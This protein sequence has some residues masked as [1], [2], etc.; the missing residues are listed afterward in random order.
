[1]F[2][3]I[4][5]SFIP[6]VREDILKGIKDLNPARATLEHD[7]PTKILKEKADLTKKFPHLALNECVQTRKFLSCLK[8]ADITPVFSLKPQGIV[9]TITDHSAFY[10]MSQKYL[11]NTCSNKCQIFWEFILHGSMWL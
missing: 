8:Q 11:K 5:F 9:K 6:V 4:Y 7:I 2:P 1:M 10:Q 3:D